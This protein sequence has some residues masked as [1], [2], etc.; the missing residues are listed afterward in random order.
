MAY[1]TKPLPS[2]NMPAGDA[3]HRRQRSRRAVQ[4]LRHDDD[5]CRL[6]DRALARSGRDA[7]RMSE[8]DAKVYYHEFHVGGLFFSDSR[9]AA[10]PMALLGKYRTILSFS[11]VYCLGHLALAID[12]TR[13][14]LFAGLQL[15]R[16]RLGRHQALRFR[17]RRRS[18]RQDESAFAS[19]SIRLVLFRDQLRVIV[20]DVADAEALGTSIVDRAARRFWRARNADVLWRRWYSGWGGK[21]CAHSARRPRVSPRDV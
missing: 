15:D 18:I 10:S 8:D 13:V 5:S 16:R 21:V 3:V 19:E 20:F 2:P 6:H 11:V 1:L 9:G 12:D 7:R 17:S 4:L 14:G